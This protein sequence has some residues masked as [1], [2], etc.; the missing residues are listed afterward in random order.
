MSNQLILWI[1]IGATALVADLITNVFLFIWF[2]IGSIAAII[3]MTLG[4]S[5]TVQVITFV[6]VSAIF[7]AVGYPLVKE[8]IK[9]TV[10]KTPTMEQGYIGRK[11][12]VDEEVMGKAI[13]KFDGIYWTIK[14]IGEPIKKGDSIE[15]SGI[16]GNKLLVKKVK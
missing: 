5:M 4:Y 10:K 16:E 1:I 9:K 7:M 6:A 3:A 13:I 14:N 15:I 8:T 12:T 2:T 11:I